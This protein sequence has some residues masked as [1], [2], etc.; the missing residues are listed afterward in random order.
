MAPSKVDL[1]RSD[2]D[3]VTARRIPTILVDPEDQKSLL[4]QFKRQRLHFSEGYKKNKPLC[5]N[6]KAFQKTHPSKQH[7]GQ[8]D[9]DATLASP[10]LLG[11]C[12]G[13]SQVSELG[14]D[15]SELPR[16]LLVACED[17][18]SS[19][20]L[21]A[22][23]HQPV[24]GA[25]YGGPISLLKQAYSDTSSFGSTSVLLAVMDNTTQIH[26]KLH[27]MIG[28]VT[29]GDCE[30]IILRRSKGPMQPLEVLLHTEMQRIGGHNQT[31]LQ[32]ARIDRSSS[33]DSDED[34]AGLDAIERGS[35]LHCTS[36]SEGDIIIVGSDGV[37]DNLFLQEVVGIINRMLPPRTVR[38]PATSEALQAIAKCIVEAAHNKTGLGCSTPVGPG[39]K[40]DDTSVVVAEVVEWTPAKRDA[41]T[42]S[43]R[44]RNGWADLF[45]CG[46]SHHCIQE[47]SESEG[48]DEEGD[49]R[50]SIS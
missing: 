50:C 40:A 42:R 2:S 15:A 38:E 23:G 29:L 46:G 21:I 14:L 4:D 7:A 43:R 34:A 49:T 31:P 19:Q 26:G 27:P 18:A 37:F 8:V 24:T 39:G 10:M 32:L 3:V 36:T 6:A 47:A 44:G 41:F 1:L 22:E 5:F 20:L 11:I 17:I 33:R 13:V 45:T 30:L 25:N 12:D 16:E 9:A 35:G 48:S 28:V